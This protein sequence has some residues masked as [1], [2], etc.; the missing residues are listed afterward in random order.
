MLFDCNA[1]QYLETVT[2]MQ[3]ALIQNMKLESQVTSLAFQ[4]HLVQ[5]YQLTN[6]QTNKQTMNICNETY[7]TAVQQIDAVFCRH[8]QTVMTE[9][10]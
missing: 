4:V 10:A 7:W 3:L 5:C 1:L 9:H 6:K 8:I 2:Q